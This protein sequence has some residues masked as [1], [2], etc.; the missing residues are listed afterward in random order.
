[1]LLEQIFLDAVQ[2]D[3]GGATITSYWNDELLLSFET[4]VNAT[5]T[6]EHSYKYTQAHG[7]TK[8]LTH[9]HTHTYTLLCLNC[10]FLHF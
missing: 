3:V 7:H 8:M 6:H 4:P 1:M 2:T 9:A 10:S 5:K